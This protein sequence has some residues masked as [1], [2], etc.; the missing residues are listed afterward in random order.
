MADT[1]R[2]MF[3][4]AFVALIIPC[5]LSTVEAGKTVKSETVMSVD[6]MMFLME[7]GIPEKEINM[8]IEAN[9]SDDEIVMIYGLAG[10]D[11]GSGRVKSLSGLDL[12]SGR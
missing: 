11:L 12:G 5:G 8:L 3:C 10:L 9:M 4:L 2:K 1:V 7:S 6:M